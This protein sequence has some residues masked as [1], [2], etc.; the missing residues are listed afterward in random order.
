VE[1][2]GVESKV[3]SLEDLFRRVVLGKLGGERA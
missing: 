3:A 1:L 2:Y